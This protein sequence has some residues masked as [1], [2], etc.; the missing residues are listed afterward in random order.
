[1]YFPCCPKKSQ[2]DAPYPPKEKQIKSKNHNPYRNRSETSSF[3]MLAINYGGKND[4]GGAGR[5]GYHQGR[6]GHSNI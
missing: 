3:I 4:R 6:S 2:V 1:M 5:R